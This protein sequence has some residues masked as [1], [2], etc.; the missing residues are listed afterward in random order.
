MRRIN[1]RDDRPSGAYRS[2]GAGNSAFFFL[3]S[4]FQEPSGLRRRERRD[5]HRI[6]R[7]ETTGHINCSY[8]H[9]A[10]QRHGIG[11]L[12]LER[13]E[14]EARGPLYRGYRVR[15]FVMEKNLKGDD[16]PASRRDRSKKSCTYR[17]KRGIRCIS[18]RPFSFF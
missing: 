13:I 6:R 8:V 5:P 7:F 9:H 15:Q 17:A 2:L 1:A 3:G 11:A 16:L 12:L 18:T 14:Q 10:W 4:A